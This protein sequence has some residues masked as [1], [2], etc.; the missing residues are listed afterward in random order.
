MSAS[1]FSD[2][3]LYEDGIVDIDALHSET[4]NSAGRAKTE[5]LVR[6]V[7]MKA[8]TRLKHSVHGGALKAA[9]G[10]KSDSG[11][12][13]TADENPHQTCN[14]SGGDN[15]CG[16]GSLAGQE[17]VCRVAKGGMSSEPC[18]GT[19]CSIAPLN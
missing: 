12:G 3:I 2:Q 11:N 15:G 17:T 13:A 9:K 7:R 18:G 16:R 5:D 1:R 4:A 14:Q 19:T 10:L 6:I 8:G